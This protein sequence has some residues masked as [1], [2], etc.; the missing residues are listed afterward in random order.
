[1]SSIFLSYSRGDDELFVRRLY[2]ELTA[3]GLSV[4]FDRVSMPSRRLTFHQ[5]IRDAVAACERFV[6]VVGPH[7][8]ASDYVRQEWQFA[9]FDAEKVIT[10]VLRMGEYSLVPDEL[11]LLHC[12]DFREDSQFDIHLRTLERILGDPPPRLGELIGVPSLP[13]YFL[14]RTDRLVALRDAVRSGLD[15][16]VSLG[17]AVT[18]QK[19]LG[20]TGSTKRVG[21]H[22]MGGIG[23]SFLA[24]LLAHDRQVRESFP[25]GIV[26][27]SLGASPEIR[28]HMV[29]VHR[30]FGCD[31]AIE[32]EPEGKQKLVEL[33]KD[34]AVLLVLDDAWH[35]PDVDFFDVLGPR[36][37][38][39]VTTR[40][41]GLIR[42]ING[43]IHSVELLSNDEA[44][45][46]LT[47]SADLERSALPAEALEVLAQCGRLPLAVALAGSRVRAGISWTDLRDALREHELEFLED[48][49]ATNPQHINLWRMI[50]VSV[51][52]LAND[53][54]HRFAELAVLCPFGKRA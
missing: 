22:G 1:M 2:G 36:C 38:A 27:V 49:Q 26:W 50:E 6:L 39:L 52:T 43:V 30:A 10:P 4:W 3:R 53:V 48:T 17:G 29:E 32:N 13:A 15:S 7:A 54:Q 45:R 35:R 51:A 47:V 25:D 8:A 40:D 41:A 24:N 9:W 37:R 5:E 23:K 31:G 28:K 20:I 46:L 12:E 11:K 44:V 14:S 42:S 18:Y 34:K 19:I 16:P 21:L 33:L